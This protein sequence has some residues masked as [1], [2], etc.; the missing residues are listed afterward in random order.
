MIPIK[1]GSQI[2]KM[3]KAGKIT[4]DVLRFIEP[5]V[6]PGVTTLQLDALIE[7]YIRAQGAVPC[8]KGLYGFPGSA[9][10]SIDDVVV[11]GIPSNRQLKEGEIVSI[12]VGAS[13]DGFNGD[14][15]R[16]FAVGK[17]SEEKQ[18]LIDV[19]KQSFFEGIKYAR[20]G[21]RVGDI[22]HAIQS[23]VE[24]NGYSVVRSMCGHGIGKSVHE[25]PEV[26]NYGSAGTGPL[27]KNGYCLAIE[28]MVNMGTFK[29]DISRLDGWTCRTLDKKPS[30]HY[31]NTVLI[32]GTEP[33]ILTLQS[34]TGQ[35]QF[36]KVDNL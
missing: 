28:P 27:L 12:D 20:A 5:Y 8:F 23:Y 17:I 24:K 7:E 35:K 22:S 25:D 30:A 11:H 4:G 14:A 29:V 33:E 19:T 21:R 16:T 10:I 2:D 1:V 32:T 6:V 3:R 31:E 13:I 34:K 18:R 9:C 36:T 26:P 15:A